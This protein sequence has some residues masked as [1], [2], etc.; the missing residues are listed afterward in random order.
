MSEYV[1]QFMAPVDNLVAY[2]HH[3][4]PLYFVQHFVD[5]FRVDICAAVIVQRPP[6]LDSVSVLALL[7][8]APRGG[9]E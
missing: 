2:G 7:L 4:D 8:R 6:S 3:T 9:G 5:G 1:E